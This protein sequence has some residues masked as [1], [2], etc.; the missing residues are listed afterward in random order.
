VQAQS[1]LDIS[2]ERQRGQYAI[3]TRG[4]FIFEKEIDGVENVEVFK[5]IW[6]RQNAGRPL[7]D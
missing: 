6:H 5:S 3:L 1:E 2:H 7:A 4:T